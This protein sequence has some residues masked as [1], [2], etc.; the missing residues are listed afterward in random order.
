MSSAGVGVEEAAMLAPGDS[1]RSLKISLTD[2]ARKGSKA[3]SLRA[4][5]LSSPVHAALEGELRAKGAAPRQRSLELSPEHLMLA[6]VNAKSQLRWWSL[7]PDPRRLRSEV[8][9]SDG[10]LAGVVLYQPQAEFV[11]NLPFDGE[12][13]ELR[14]YHPLWTGEGFTLQLLGAIPLPK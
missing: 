10:T 4:E 7:I 13:V 8:P 6:T 11:V 1:S 5:Q 14:F 9:G 12:A 2:P 3:S